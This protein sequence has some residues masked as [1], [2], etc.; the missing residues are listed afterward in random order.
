MP[1]NGKFLLDTNVIIGLF[2]N[3]R[4][5]L[6]RLRKAKEVFVPAI[7]IGELFY[8]ANRSTQVR[9]NVAR[10][11]EFAAANTVLPC[12]LETARHY[13]RVKDRL[14][15]KGRPL[16]ENDIWIASLAQQHGLTLVSRDAHFAGVERLTVKVW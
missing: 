16:P 2:A 4:K 6:Q 5:L 1:M 11:E 8:G 9:S 10:I 7:A 15:R 12:D 14:R 13:G 3:E